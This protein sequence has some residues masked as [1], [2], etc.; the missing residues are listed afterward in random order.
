M[1]TSGSIHEQ[2][3]RQALRAAQRAWGETHPNPMVG[4]VI[5]EEG[6][7]MAEGYHARAGQA[8]AEVDVLNALGR[9]PAPEA[10]LYVTLEPCSTCGRTPPCTER[11]IESGIRKVVIGAIDPNPAH[12]GRGLDILVESGVDVTSGTLAEECEELNLI[13]NHNMRTGQPLFAGKIA[14]T[15]DGMIATRS[16]HSQWITGPAA[17]RDV[18][19][20]RRYFPAIAVAAGTVL[21]DNPRL[22]A[23]IS[24]DAP[25]CP[26]RFIFDRDLR[27]LASRAHVLTD[28]YAERTTLVCAPDADPQRKNEA[29]ALGVR[30]VELPHQQQRPCMQAFRE[31]C[32]QLSITGVL[33]E[34]GGAL[35]SHLI[36]EEALD[37][38]FHY[39]AAKLLADRDARPAFFGR[40]ATKMDEAITLRGVRQA[41]LADDQLMRGFLH[42]PQSREST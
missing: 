20:W 8:H 10:I 32:K 9:P 6:I 28:E 37:Y 12:A 2:F 25:F 30:Y 4:A 23:R 14:T 11:I 19:L 27:T 5:V 3:M 24:E 26:Q 36:A 33:F 41:M 18:M 17:R 21:A 1:P 13:F 35:L 16:G 31:H 40:T 42:Y 39:R 22:S 29:A 34:G 15:L 38:L 7:V